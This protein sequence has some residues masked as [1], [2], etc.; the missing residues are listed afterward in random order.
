MK[1][2]AM[3]R[4]VILLLAAGATPAFAGPA[5]DTPSREF[6]ALKS[7]VGVWEGTTGAAK[8]V[9]T[10]YRLVSGDTVLM[11]DYTVEGENT[12]MVSM[13][14][15]DGNRLILTHYCMA[16]NQP[17]LVGK[18]TG[19]SPTTI[20]FTFL[21]ATNVKGPKDGHVHGAVFKLVDN[22]T[23]DQEWTFRKEGKDS[24][25]EVFHYKRTK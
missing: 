21:D 23:L 10:T 4:A 11:E 13:Y 2:A 9:H 7:L 3:S 25:K 22:Q 1:K 17:R 14:H 19:Q 15:P 12:N 24:E 6:E 8:K 20:T 18:I 5:A 16:N